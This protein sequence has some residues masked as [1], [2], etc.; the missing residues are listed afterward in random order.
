[1]HAA[2]YVMLCADGY[3][4]LRLEYSLKISRIFFSKK[5]R[6]KFRSEVSARGAGLNSFPP[7]DDGIVK[8]LEYCRT[9][10]KCSMGSA[11]GTGYHEYD[12]S[13]SA[14]SSSISIKLSII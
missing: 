10:Q 5:P 1:M 9:N 4:F 14:L 2:G 3:E 13:S 12:L 7:R 8:L 6:N 11:S